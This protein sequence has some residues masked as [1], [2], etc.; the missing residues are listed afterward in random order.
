MARIRSIKP[1]F[2]GDSKVARLSLQARL[3]FLLLLP[4]CDDDGRLVASPKRLAGM[5]YPNDD[6]IGPKH[7]EKWI[8]ELVKEGM[9]V[10]YEVDGARYLA[11]PKFRTHQTPQHP[12]ASVLPP[13]PT[14]LD[15]CGP[16]E[17]VMKEAGSAHEALI[18][19]LNGSGRGSGR[20]SMAPAPP[21]LEGDP[22]ASTL[23]AVCGVSPDDVTGSS[24][25]AYAKAVADL[26]AVGAA[27]DEVR[28]R[29][30][31]YR[32]RWPEASLT[33]TALVRRWGECSAGAALQPVVAKGQAALLRAQARGQ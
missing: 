9:V 28:H 22:L 29:A 1:S 20:G 11:V 13:P 17:S 33:P 21:S 4:E 25:G 12:K 7:V 27:P 10:L 5:L 19:D 23:L 6:N 18:P 31:A 30:A 8:G 15:S 16:H 2:A 32:L 26:R 3:T 24:R 14:P